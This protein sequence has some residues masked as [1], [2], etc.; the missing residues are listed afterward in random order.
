MVHVGREQVMEDIAETGSFDFP[1][2][3]LV[4][5]FFF[6]FSRGTSRVFSALWRQAFSS[7]FCYHSRSFVEYLPCFA[8]FALFCQSLLG[9]LPNICFVL[10]NICIDLP[11]FA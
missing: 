7:R 2:L 8:K 4:L 1:R 9:V 11:I 5:A 10:P 3:P 6:V